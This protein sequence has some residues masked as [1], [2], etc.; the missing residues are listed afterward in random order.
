MRPHSTSCDDNREPILSCIKPYLKDCKTLLEIASGTG[1]HAVYFA[2][3]LPHLNWQ[4]SELQEHISG[5]KQWLESSTSLNVLPPIELDVSTHWPIQKYDA[6]FSANSLHIMNHQLVED[7]FKGISQVI[8]HGGVCLIY[9]PFNY[10]KQYTSDSNQRFDQWLKQ[11]GEGSCIKD[12]ESI[13]VLANSANLS[14]VN[15]H[16]M[17]ANNRLLVFKATL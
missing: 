3:D 15:D 17:P 12:F 14:L 2:P 11:R 1:Q 4:P 16:D 9:G 8:K 10:N 13:N 6:I 7:F 5:I